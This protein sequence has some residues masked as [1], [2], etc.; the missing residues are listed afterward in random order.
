MFK[1]KKILP[2][3]TP[4]MK[5]PKLSEMNTEVTV[6]KSSNPRRTTNHP[7]LRRN[8]RPV[9]MWRQKNPRW[10]LNYNGD[11]KVDVS[12]VYSS[13]R[14]HSC[15][16]LSFNIL[17]VLF[18]R[19]RNI[20]DLL[21]SSSLSLPVCFVHLLSIR[22]IAD[23]KLWTH[24]FFVRSPAKPMSFRILMLYWLICL[25]EVM[26]RKNARMDATLSTKH[27]VS[28]HKII[29]FQHLSLSMRRQ[30]SADIFAFFWRVF[31]IHLGQRREKKK[32]VRLYLCTHTE[33]KKERKNNQRIELKW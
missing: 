18:V 32:N 24:F 29:V 26:L 7:P 12:H 23:R 11:T 14:S 4:Q 20:F 13:L 1:E 22:I 33:R 17:A 3:K 27:V 31:F 28:S 15:I 19:K 25:C 9:L 16:P 2:P 21:F 30:S 10:I 6:T 5:T 8:Q